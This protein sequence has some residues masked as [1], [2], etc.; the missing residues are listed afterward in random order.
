MAN[1]QRNYRQT[2][3]PQPMLRDNLLLAS[4]REAV[5]RCLFPER[6]IEKVFDEAIERVREENKLTE[7]K[8]S[9]NGHRT[10]SR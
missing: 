1:I 3:D 2:T 6:H 9:H 5:S 8:V 4:V 10:D 7:D